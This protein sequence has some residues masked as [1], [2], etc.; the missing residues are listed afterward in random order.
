[1]ASEGNVSSQGATPRAFHCL[2]ESMVTSISSGLGRVMVA[3]MTLAWVLFKLLFSHLPAV[4]WHF[5]PGIMVVGKSHQGLGPPRGQANSLFSLSYPSDPS[6]GTFL[7]YWSKVES[8]RSLCP[9]A[10]RCY[11][12]PTKL[13]CSIICCPPSLRSDGGSSHRGLSRHTKLN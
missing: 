12:K 4:S 9:F 1:M 2:D 7:F 13:C 5:T 10:D 8:I 11:P 3:I 6:S